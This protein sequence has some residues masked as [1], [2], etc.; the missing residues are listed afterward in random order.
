ML[1]VV[2]A[3]TLAAV[4]VVLGRASDTEVVS[5]ALKCL[6]RA[7]FVAAYHG[8]DEVRCGIKKLE[9]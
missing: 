3:P 5:G 1:T 9:I 4:S 8:M 6:M 7:A 2:W